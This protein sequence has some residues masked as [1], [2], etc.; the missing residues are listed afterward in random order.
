[1]EKPIFQMNKNVTELILI[2]LQNG[3][4]EGTMFLNEDK[5]SNDFKRIERED[6]SDE[7]LIYSSVK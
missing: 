2:T 5:W 7:N 6:I 1:M 4:E 3:M